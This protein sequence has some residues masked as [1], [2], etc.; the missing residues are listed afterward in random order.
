MSFD[1][2]Q[3]LTESELE[4]YGKLNTDYDHDFILLF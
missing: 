4:R 1:D 3:P 2:R